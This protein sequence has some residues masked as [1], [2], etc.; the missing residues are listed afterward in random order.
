MNECMNLAYVCQFR[1]SGKI[2]NDHLLTMGKDESGTG[3][4][5]CGLASIMT[6]E[7]EVY[8]GDVDRI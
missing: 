3:S 7:V 1:I 6:G 2:L 5:R 8:I 4:G